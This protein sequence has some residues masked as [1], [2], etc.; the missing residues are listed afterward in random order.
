MDTCLGSGH[1]LRQGGADGIPKIA[2]TKNLLNMV[3]DRM[4]PNVILFS[5]QSRRAGLHNNNNSTLDDISYQKKTWL[6]KEFKI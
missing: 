4:V 3:I 6:V 2:R 5:C 1:Y